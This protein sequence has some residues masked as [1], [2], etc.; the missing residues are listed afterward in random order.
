MDTVTGFKMARK[1]DEVGGLGI[2]HRYFSLDEYKKIILEWPLDKG[3]LAFSVGTISKDKERIDWC[4][5]NSDI[6]CVDIAHGDSLHMQQTLNY[7]RAK[8]FNRPLIAGNVVTLDAAKALI[9]W[10][11]DMVKVGVGPGSVCTTRI[12]T[13][14]GYPQLSA[15]MECSKTGIP[16]IAD[17]GI[18]TEGDAAKALAA[19]ATA[20]MIGG[21]LA[22]TDCVPGWNEA[23]DK[24]NELSF[25]AGSRLHYI[26]G[27]VF[28]D[29]PTI[30]YRGMASREAREAFTGAP[31]S[32]AEGVSRNIE[33][34]P[35]G[36]TEAVV[37]EIHE[38]IV[39]AM[40]YVGARTLKEFRYKKEFIRVTQ[41]TTTENHPHF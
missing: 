35:E 5:Q 7:I 10:G 38:G 36:S 15:I 41:A 3:P 34:K 4:I 40:S 8:E 14:C 31:S 21:M 9:E 32:N 2:I 19:G 26:T 29:S 28:P 1:M 25:T 17:G 22:G 18:K 33:C 11:A 12:K 20:I 39:S 27:K 30:Q 24:Y 37:R 16:V 6:I 13:G 23:M